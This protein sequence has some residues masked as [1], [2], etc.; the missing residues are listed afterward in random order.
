MIR[1]N[2][3]DRIDH[4]MIEVDDPQVTYQDFHKVFALPQAWPLITSE[5][6]TSIGVNFGNAN[7]E[8]ISF[9]ERFGV[10]NT[11]YSGLSGVCLTCHADYENIKANLNCESIELLDGEDAP[12]HKTVVIASKTAPTLF[13]CYYKFNTDGWRTRLNEEYKKSEGGKFNITKIEEV[14]ID[15]PLLEKSEFKFSQPNAIK[16]R[17]SKTP[18]VRLRSARDSLIGKSMFV[19][20]TLFSFC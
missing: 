4:L 10:V 16:L 3:F 8:L 15:N 14:C 7:I 20:E 6:Y 17:F 2:L 9:K 18:E 13:V 12:G 5:K 11:R 1:L 19:G